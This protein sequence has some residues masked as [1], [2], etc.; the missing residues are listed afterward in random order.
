MK[1]IAGGSLVA[2]LFAVSVVSAGGNVCSNCPN[3]AY[4]GRVVNSAPA[5][6]HSAT[7]AAAPRTVVQANQG[8]RSFSYEPATAAQVPQGG[9]AYRSYS[10]TP[11]ATPTRSYAPSYTRSYYQG[12]AGRLNSTPKSLR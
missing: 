9:A 8:Y 6:V 5:V 11:A 10:Y 1:M 7:I 2:A 12:G 4:S 3:G